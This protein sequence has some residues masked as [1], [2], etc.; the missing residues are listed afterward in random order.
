MIVYSDYKHSTT[1]SMAEKNKA[2]D[3]LFSAKGNENPS[4]QSQPVM[5]YI[6]GRAL[7]HRTNGYDEEPGESKK[8][9]L[10]GLF[11]QYRPSKVLMFHWPHWGN[12]NDYSSPAEDAKSAGAALTDLL[13]EIDRAAKEKKLSGPLILLSHS[14]G[15][16]VLQQALSHSPNPDLK[17]FHTVAIFASASRYKESWVWLSKIKTANSYVFSNE[18]DPVLSHLHNT[19]GECGVSCLL[20]E[21]R[22]DGIVYVDITPLKLGHRYFVSNN[23]NAEQRHLMDDVI[24]PMLT[25]GKPKFDGAQP[26]AGKK[27]YVVHPK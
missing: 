4:A 3:G 5:I 6:H 22:A 25:R 27:I 10:P 16:I 21:Q 1:Y 17:N 20:S 7:G 15:S 2:I 23:P 24:Q 19:I 18:H 14:M 13:A 26:N 11:S 8:D 12:G 9:V